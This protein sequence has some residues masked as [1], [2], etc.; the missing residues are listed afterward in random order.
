MALSELY[1]RVLAWAGPDQLAQVFVTGVALLAVAGVL[2]AL[3]YLAVFARML[4]VLGVLTLMTLMLIL[5]DQTTVEQVSPEVRV[6]R[7]KYPD[8]MRFLIRVALYAVTP[9]S[10]I[11]K[12]S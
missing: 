1:S 4:G 11:G 3:G 6:T 8:D 5:H 10:G 7:A 2:L 9:F 12:K